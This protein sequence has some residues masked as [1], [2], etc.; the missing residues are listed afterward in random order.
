MVNNKLTNNTPL[1]LKQ[2][3][4]CQ[5]YTRGKYQG[6]ATQSYRQ[7][8]QNKMTDNQCA[9]GARDMLR[10]PHI[11]ARIQALEN[12]RYFQH[13]VDEDSR[14]DMIT[15]CMKGA[16]KQKQWGNMRGSINEMNRMVGGHKEPASDQIQ[17][18]NNVQVNLL[19]P[20]NGR[21]V[22]KEEE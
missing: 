15:R 14:L 2:E 22:K 8:Y 21:T 10:L 12:D 9:K 5:E 7:A 16:E 11:G 1:T 17:S 3:R 13:G 19:V 6:N 18:A 4:F 20:N